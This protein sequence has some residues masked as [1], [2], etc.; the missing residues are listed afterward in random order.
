MTFGS[1]LSIQQGAST[2]SCTVRRNT[3]ANAFAAE[4]GHRGHPISVEGQDEGGVA[5]AAQLL[6]ERTK[7]SAS[8]ED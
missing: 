8:E 5:V 3:Q 6:A 1:G 4:R 2:A 7:S